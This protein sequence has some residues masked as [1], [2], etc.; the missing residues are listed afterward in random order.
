MS[1][2]LIN[3]ITLISLIIEN[4]TRKG[5]LWNPWISV[6]RDPDG[7]MMDAVLGDALR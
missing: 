6:I 3:Q 2:S 1:E 7:V 5:N 4:E